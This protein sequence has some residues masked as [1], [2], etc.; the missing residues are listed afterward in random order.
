MDGLVKG[1][2]VPIVVPPVGV[3]NHSKVPELAVAVRLTLPN[4]HVTPPFA[5]EIVGTEFT[6]M[7]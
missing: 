4:P 2:P 6:T 5:F 7:V 3:V 1:E